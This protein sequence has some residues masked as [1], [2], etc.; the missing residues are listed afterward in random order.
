MASVIKSGRLIPSGTAVQHIEFNLEDM[1]QS[2]SKY[3]DTVRQ[4]AARI[5][6]EAQQ[7]AQKL[8][9]EAKLQG[10]EAAEQ[11]A[12]Q[13]AREEMA[14]RWQTLTPTL[15]QAID[16]ATRLKVAWVQQWE[17]S[18][19]QLVIAIAERV[20]RRE[21]SQHPE[22]SQ[23]W[24]R[25]ALELASGSATLTLLLHPDDCAALEASR[26]EITQQFSHLATA[27][28][29]ADASISPGG[30]RVLTDHGQIDQQLESH[31][32]RITEELTS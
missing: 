4:K 22:I 19:L 9:A 21:L 11:A 3:L 2:A 31:L 25:E 15:Q 28:I 12:R 20:I 8:Q 14:A 30:C 6:V 10:R 24:I 27:R 26:A 13:A 23:Q 16:D 18:I 17:Q 32:A 29:V 7:Q 1:S 5:L